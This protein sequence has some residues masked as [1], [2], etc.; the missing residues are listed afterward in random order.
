MLFFRR[1]CCWWM[2]QPIVNFTYSHA[3]DSLYWPMCFQLLYLLLKMRNRLINI[4][5]ELRVDGFNI[6]ACER[7]WIEL[8]LCARWCSI[9]IQQVTEEF[10]KMIINF[11][12]RICTLEFAWLDCVKFLQNSYW[13]RRNSDQDA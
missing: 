7:H 10:D 13:R 4:E 11:A 1:L 6:Y 3:S 8:I 9:R 12:R 5:R 2:Y